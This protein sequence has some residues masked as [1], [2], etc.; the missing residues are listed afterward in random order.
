MRKNDKKAAKKQEASKQTVRQGAGM[1]GSWGR[2]DGR[3]V[4]F[5]AMKAVDRADAALEKAAKFIESSKLEMASYFQLMALLEMKNFVTRFR[6]VISNS[7]PVGRLN[8]YLCPMVNRIENIDYECKQFINKLMILHHWVI[9]KTMPL[10]ER[11]ILAYSVNEMEEKFTDFF[12]EF[13]CVFSLTAIIPNLPEVERKLNDASDASKARL[14]AF[15]E[16]I[17]DY[18]GGKQSLFLATPKIDSATGKFAFESR[19]I[20]ASA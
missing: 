5:K 19:T 8:S 15:L 4:T 1:D 9:N 14:Q 7:V 11:N 18:S 20:P 2:A 6:I 10:E 13:I 17:P 16:K 3:G 12:K